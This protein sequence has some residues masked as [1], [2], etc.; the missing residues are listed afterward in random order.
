MKPQYYEYTNERT[1]DAIEVNVL[2]HENK[3]C[4]KFIFGIQLLR[5][6]AVICM[7]L[8]FGNGKFT[9]CCS[10]PKLPE[11]DYKLACERKCLKPYVGP[12]D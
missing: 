11:Q 2:P 12:V 9:I 7:S 3:N 10:V 8:G 6:W 1:C 5:I 4:E